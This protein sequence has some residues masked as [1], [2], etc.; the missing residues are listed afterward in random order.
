MLH[1]KGKSPLTAPEVVENEVVCMRLAQSTIQDFRNVPEDH[2]KY[3]FPFLHYLTS[4]IIT[5][6]GLIIKQSRF[7]TP[8]GGLTLEATRS[9]KNHSRKTWVSG[10]MA[11]AVWKLNQMAEAI[12]NTGPR[13]DE[14]SNQ[15]QPRPQ[16][17]QS[18]HSP[19]RLSPK[20]AHG[21]IMPAAS[22]QG[23]PQSLPQADQ[24]L[25]GSYR[26]IQI[27]PVIHPT[28]VDSLVA[29]HTPRTSS[30]RPEL[31]FGHQGEVPHEIETIGVAPCLP[32]DTTSSAWTIPPAPFAAPG[33]E[34]FGSDPNVWL[35]GEMIDDGME[36]LQSLC[37]ND[38][39]PH[40]QIPW[41]W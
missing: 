36:W 18:P 16:V 27:D 33:A 21:G 30:L 35:P 26:Q 38:L 25:A 39:D 20:S 40:V 13:Q 4:A 32:N 8:Y 12:L 2:P 19:H 28:H 1:R 17:I 7:K 34:M 10:K 14:H 41:T 31:H 37:A 24:P 22:N 6:L 9:L 15:N 29:D 11:R 23:L 3:T 5:A